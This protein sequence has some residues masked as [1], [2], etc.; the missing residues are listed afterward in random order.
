MQTFKAIQE[1]SGEFEYLG[2]VYSAV[3]ECIFNAIDQMDYDPSKH[4]TPNAE[5]S[6]SPNCQRSRRRACPCFQDKTV[7]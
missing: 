6:K 7:F 2:L 1:N 5:S 4:V 3:C